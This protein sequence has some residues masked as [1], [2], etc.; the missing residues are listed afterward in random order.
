MIICRHE[1]KRGIRSILLWSLVIGGM[2]VL[3]LLLY[4]ELKD[5]AKGLEDMMKNLGSFTAAFGMDRLAYGEVMGF[6]GIYAGAMLGIG[7]MFYAAILGS[8]MLAKEEREKTAEFLMTHPIKRSRIYMEK[9]AAM[10]IQ[11]FLM[12]GIVVALSLLGF[13]MIGETPE[14]KEFWLFHGAQGV[15]QTEI[16]CICYGVSSFLR[17]GDTSVGIGIASLFYF[18]GVYA[19]ITEKAEAVKYITPY[20]YADAAEIIST[21]SLNGKLMLLGMVYALTGLLIGFY[22]YQKKDI[23]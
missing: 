2:N 19:N 11:L 13:S 4:P 7:G 15:M 10:M 21:A 1:I 16:V 20:A 9:L 8:G 12:N 18:L 22:W 6:Y 14:W 3:C 5:E 23:I 17:K